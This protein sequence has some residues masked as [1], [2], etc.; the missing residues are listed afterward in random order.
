MTESKNI[1]SSGKPKIKRITVSVK[2]YPSSKVTAYGE[3]IFYRDGTFAIADKNAYGDRKS[4]RQ[5]L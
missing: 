2:D 3:V 5:T 4:E 1:E